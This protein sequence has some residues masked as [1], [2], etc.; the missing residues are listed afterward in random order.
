M[1]RGDH[2]HL[3]ADAVW[4]AARARLPELSLATVY[5]TLNEL[6]AMGEV[7]EVSAG[8][9]PK[10]YDPNVAPPHQH[11]VCVECGEL[12]DVHPAGDDGLRL[13]RSERHGYEIV[14]V[15]IVFRGR[16]RRCRSP[17]RQRRPAAT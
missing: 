5:N 9:G 8:G 15:E 16:C 10:R 14:D 11:L 6:V 7:V 3:T 13:P 4:A 12:L 17:R 2:V 1:L